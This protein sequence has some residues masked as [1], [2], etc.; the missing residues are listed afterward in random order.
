MKLPRIRTM[1]NLFLG[2]GLL[3][4]ITAIG[5]WLFHF[6]LS[7]LLTVYATSA[8]AGLVYAFC[9]K[10]RKRHPTPNE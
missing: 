4:A 9:I 6:H 7:E 2:M 3:A 5:I 1:E 8:V 10:V